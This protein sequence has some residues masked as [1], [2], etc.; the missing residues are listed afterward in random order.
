M[1]PHQGSRTRVKATLMAL[2]LGLF[3]VLVVLS[4]VSRP[5]QAAAST[6]LNFQ[7][8]LLSNTGAIVADGNYN[9][10]FKIYNADSTTG[11]VGTCTS[12]CLWEETRKNFNSQGVRV[13]NG[14][15]S[16]Q[17]GSVT[18]FPAINWDQQLWLTMN[19]G[20]TSV[21]ASPTWDG[22]MQSSGHSIQLTAVPLAFAANQLAT[23]TGSSRGTLSFASLGQATAITLP[24][25]ASGTATVCYQTA[26]AC[27]FAPSS[28]STVY[29]TRQLDNLSSV[30][31]N[32]SLLPASDN[33]IDIGDSSTHSFRTGYFD[34]S[35]LGPLFD[36]QSAGTLSV[37]TSTATTI[38]IG[39]VGSTTKA[40]AVHIADT[41]DATNAQTVTIGSTAKTTDVTTIQ[42]GGA[43]S[44][45]V[46]QTAASGGIDIGVNNVNPKTIN[47]GSVGSTAGGTTVHIADTSTTTNV[48]AVTI[49]SIGAAAHTTLIQGGN[50]STA[51]QLQ[52]A[53]SGTISI[54][55]NAVS[56]T[57]QIGTILGNSG[58]TQTIGIGNLNNPGTTNITIG[59]DSTATGGTTTLQSKGTLTIGSGVS[60][61]INIRAVTGATINIGDNAV[62]S[63][64]TIGKTGST[65][66][67]ATIHVGDTTSG[68]GAQTITIGG[69]GATNGSNT[70]TTV[71][72]QAGQ[73]A[74][75]L[76]NAGETLQTFTNSSTAFRAQ[77]SIGSNVLLADT[78]ALNANLTNSNFEGTDVSAWTAKGTASAPTRDTSNGA[79]LGSAALQVVAGTT[80]GNGIK[81]VTTS[82]T[83][84]ATYALSFYVKQI[85]GTALTSSNFE[86]GWNNGT[87]DSVCSSI[88]PTLA[89]QAP[90]TSG[91]VRYQCTFTA[92][93]AGGSHLY[94]KILSGIGSSVTFDIDA[95]QIE[96]AATTTAYKETGLQ[97]NGLVASPLNLQ[98]SSDSTR[99]FSIQ[100][101]NGT[102]IFAVDSLNS[103]IGI[104]TQPT[105]SGAALQ[106]SGDILATGTLYA[107][108]GNSSLDNSGLQVNGSQ[109]INGSGDLLNIGNFTASAGS[110]FSTTGSNGF[111]FKPG[112]DIA[113]AFQV[114]NAAA[115]KTV[116]TVDTSSLSGAGQVVLGK[117]STNNGT[118]QFANSSGTNTV[119]FQLAANPASSYTLL[120]PTTAPAVSQCLQTDASVSNQLKFAAC[121]AGASGDNISINTV[122]ATDADFTD[123]AATSSVTGT[124][125][126]NAGGT[127]NQIKV[128]I[129]N[130]DATHAGAV[131]AGSQ[132]FG[133]D[134]IFGG[135]ITLANSKGLFFNGNS[136][137][138]AYLLNNSS[139]QFML[140]GGSNGT[141]LRNNA[142][143]ALLASISD[144][145]AVLLQNSTNSSTAFQIQNAAGTSQLNFDTTKSLATINATGPTYLGGG[146]VSGTANTGSSGVALSQNVV[147]GRYEYVIGS[148][149]ATACSSAVGCELQVWDISTPSTPKYVGGADSSGS[150]NAGT[151]SKG[152]FTVAISGH[153]VIVGTN[154]DHSAS[155]SQTAGSATGCEIMVF[156]VSNPA[157]PTYVGGADNTGATNSGSFATNDSKFIR[158]VTVSGRYLYVATATEN[159]GATCSATAGSA[160]GCEIQIYDF[161]NPAAPTYISGIDASGTVNGGTT[162]Q[163]DN[164]VAV[165]GRYM[166]VAKAG[167]ATACSSAIGCELQVY[168]VGNPAAPVYKG[169][170]D[171]A[172][173]TNTGTAGTTTPQYVV[174]AGRYAYIAKQGSSAAACSQTAG[175]A[176]SCEFMIFD[177]SNPASPTYAGGTDAN[178]VTNGST[179]KTIWRF[180]ISGRYAY[181]ATNPD[182]TACSNSNALGCEFTMLDVSNPA[183]ITYAGGADITGTTNSGTGSS[184]EMNNIAISGHYA[185]VVTDNNSGT[186]CTSAAGCEMQS[187]DIG[188]LDA[189]AVTAHSL[190]AGTLMVDSNGTVAGDFNIQGALAVGQS[191][192]IQ[193]DLAV[194]GSFSTFNGSNSGEIAGWNLDNDSLLATHSNSGAVA[195]NGYLYQ[196]G[197]VVGGANSAVVNYAKINADGSTSAWTATTSL[198]NALMMQPVVAANGYIYSL[199]GCTASTCAGTKYSQ[200]YYAKQLPDGT[201][202]AWQ[203]NS[204]SLG[205][206]MGGGAAVIY[207]GYVYYIGGHDG[208][209]AQTTVYYARLNADGSTGPFNTTTNISAVYGSG[210]KFEGAAIVNGYIYL[211]GGCPNACGS[212]TTVA[213]GQINSDA[214]ITSWTSTT[215]LPQTTSQSG[216]TAVNGY[217]YSIG[218]SGPNT[219]IYYAKTNS[220]GTVGSWSTSLNPLPATRIQSPNV[221]ATANGYIYVI[222]GFNGAADTST[223]YYASTARIKAGGSLDLVGSGTQTLSEPGAGG[224]LTAGN[225]QIVGSL[226]VLDQASFRN[227][228]AV[229]GI[230]SSNP[231]NPQTNANTGV[232]SGSVLSIASNNHSYL[233]LDNRELSF[234]GHKNLLNIANIQD[235]YVYDTTADR[236]GGRWTSDERAISSSWYNETIDHTSSACVVGTDDR[237]GSQSF[238]SKAILVVA[239][240]TGANTL[241]IFDAQDNS[242]WMTFTQNAGATVA[243]GVN[244]NNTM[245]SIHALNGEIYVGTNGSAPTGMYD[246]NFRTDKITRYNATDARDYASTISSRN[247]AQT[248]AYANQNRTAV[249]IPTAK[250]DDVYSTVVNGKTYVAIGM[251]NAS[252]QGLAVLN[253]TNQTVTPLFTSFVK[254]V[255]SVWY[256]ADD[257]LYALNKTDSE[258]DVWYNA[259][260]VAA[261]S[262]ASK[263]YSQATVPALS[264]GSSAVTINSPAPDALFVTNGTSDADGQ[265]NTIY[266][267]HNNGLSVIEEKQGAET[268]GAVKNYNQNYVTEEMFGD[269]RVSLPL[270]GSSTINNTL[271]AV[272]DKDASVKV[273]NMTGKGGTNITASSGVRGGAR[274]FDGTN[275]LCTGTVNNTC[276][277]NTNVDVS[278]NNFT[279]SFWLK[280]ASNT[281]TRVLVNKQATPG[282]TAGY[283]IQINASHQ[284]TSTAT[285]GTTAITPVSTKIVDDNQWHYIVVTESRTIAGSFC[286]AAGNNCTV[287]QYIDGVADG[288]ASNATQSGSMSTATQMTLMANSLGANPTAGTMDEFTF[289]STALTASQIR[290]MY[291]VGSR[292]L[293]NPNHTGATSIR[294]V[295]VAADG[296]N[297]LN[298]A[299]DVVKAVRPVLANGLVYIGT[300]AG[301]S[302]LGMDTDSL[303]DI[304]SASVNTKD[305][306][307]TNYDATN[308][309]AITSVD[310]AK[311]YGTGVLL[312]IGFNNS[313]SGGVWSEIS[314]TGLIDFLGNS[315]DPFGESLNQTNLAV[316]RVFRVTNQISTRL[317]NFSMGSSAMPQIYDLLR[318]DSNGLTLAPGS[319]IAGT[320]I[321][322]AVNTSGNTI[323][324][325]RSMGTNFGSLVSAGAVEGKNSYW[326]DEFNV[327]QT[328]ACSRSAVTNSAKVIGDYGA[329]A[330]AGCTAGNGELSFS[331]NF[332]AVAVTAPISAVCSSGV[333]CNATAG[334]PAAGYGLLRVSAVGGNGASDTV[335]SL[336]YLS[337]NTAGTL[338]G[339]SAPANLP[340]FTT[341]VKPSLVNSGSNARF[342]IGLSDRAVAAGTMPTNGAFFTNCSTA[343]GSPTCTSTTW[344]GAVT[345]SGSLVGS[346]TCT[347][348]TDTGTI[349]TSNFNYLRVEVR[350]VTDIHFF[351]DTDSTNG[352]KETECGS[353]VTVGGSGMTATGIGPFAE[354]AFMTNT[355]TTENLDIDYMRMWQDDPPAA[356]SQQ[357]QNLQDSGGGQAPLI[358]DGSL[359]ENQDTSSSFF[360]F[361]AATSEDTVFNHDVYVHGTLFADKVKANQIEGLSVFTDQIASLQKQLATNQASATNTGSNGNTSTTNIQT[362]TMTVNFNDG[363]TVGGDANFQGNVFFYKL[364]TFVE[365]T[366]FKNDVSFQRHISTGGDIADTQLE[367]GAGIQT[368]VDTSANLA[369][370]SVDGNDISGQLTVKIGDNATAGKFIT[371]KFKNPYAKKPKVLITSANDQA[372]NLK[373]Y[374]TSTTDGFTIYMLEPVPVAGTQL[375]FNYWAVE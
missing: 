170:A 219:I 70:S 363:L 29:A 150:T 134:K 323:F 131:T 262:G 13:V 114:Q 135:N 56:N 338:S 341:R 220:N 325:V 361:A 156:D 35:V 251:N 94:W 249:A 123:V 18:S 147:S 198:P 44:T 222:G 168:D 289:T 68:G 141:F 136:G 169:G 184:Q 58:N 71:T 104:N 173:Q 95:V 12:A 142:D 78:T 34:T 295:S 324:S 178:G 174:V 81:Y 320:T 362:A 59:S 281:T 86:F 108:S 259:S 209:T 181:L 175:S 26:T 199:G 47:I 19:I 16:V 3:G 305:D 241:Y 238:P 149:N 228:I 332:G 111:I 122:A 271:L 301:V 287:T 368:S 214:T 102:N 302:V 138:Q 75:N 225:T 250:V 52:T 93:T 9:I 45:I 87:S 284:L 132:S 1:H 261:N 24:D 171:S 98:N 246:I 188:G 97:L 91:W 33:A 113:T 356:D 57:I 196:V 194:N 248:T 312:A 212:V 357:A 243:M 145:G 39:S 84:A 127:P 190:E 216:V 121:S 266:A 286:N 204:N 215:A 230:I 280:T 303:V 229:D 72:A 330:G 206:A 359:T 334:T 193:G 31:I 42:G 160:V 15:F 268:G 374:V 152:F 267:A 200:V 165:S 275:Y 116:L 177:I 375:L 269:V 218:G 191:A 340:I 297:K 257:V 350:S 316:D 41:S 176:N 46:L 120:L 354:A 129:T 49:G 253:E 109:R 232:L 264:N 22:E 192:S 326:G 11:S 159:T 270:A 146:D 239:G 107:S 311:G 371:V 28:G 36:V 25:P 343:G 51:I 339:I 151:G 315:Y 337:N 298:G 369:T 144:T 237:C 366:V 101:A 99:A 335:Q 217:L 96:Q 317:D 283:I 21:G 274:T 263:F 213:Y 307:G 62:S 137:N 17:L 252:T 80:S 48:Q 30:A 27:G 336:V 6:Y 245:S 309:N 189:V 85:S 329:N 88:S 304:Y 234:G 167:D 161:S 346:V 125:W 308:G 64:I 224:M 79:Y 277:D 300:T 179:S 342:F 4:S 89:T 8:R 293:N 272:P 296:A 221:L 66:N 106:V 273:V 38:N 226:Q 367:D 110:T 290:F 260:T 54:G 256:T 328:N 372:A 348:G 306:V 5:A 7:A 233:N 205:L 313:G 124:Q 235:V 69:T 63:T 166:Y 291:D 50:G 153:Y 183:S 186:N 314:S 164:S 197:G 157:S 352:I 76:A 319:A 53:A 358:T 2:V 207:K 278:S 185:F 310:V 118:L 20:G 327:I 345:V 67:T 112:S 37:G 32:T 43:A 115:N 74:W 155:C 55:A 143:T 182:A 126:S 187:Y 172:G 100:K 373:Y 180:A 333:S 227:S 242:L 276:A 202:G 294:G 223:V 208:T 90:S 103:K 117:A 60:S 210:A 139:D 158:Q 258:L 231:G 365:K 119:S 73:T 105:A 364:V 92:S 349:S 351:V 288:T 130:A 133:G 353:G 299:S 23:G 265:S 347:A 321:M 322:K 292:A 279:I 360:S 240:S 254:E 285:N 163:G 128:N 77:N 14:Y 236:D 247:T 244:A 255:T 61:G 83:N 148:G 203:T 318:V 40:T 195:Y 82:L 201:L 154:G 140:R 10:D 65:N 211:V 331:S 282:S 344:I 370:A 355:I 162:N